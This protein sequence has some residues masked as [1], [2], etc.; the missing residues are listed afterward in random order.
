MS[1]LLDKVS[2]VESND[3]LSVEIELYKTKPCLLS[4]LFGLVQHLNSIGTVKFSCSYPE[5]MYCLGCLGY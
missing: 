1:V 5:H 3:T 2:M 4:D